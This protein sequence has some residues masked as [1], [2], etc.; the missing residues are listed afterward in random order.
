MPIT[1]QQVLIRNI[2]IRRLPSYY[3]KASSHWLIQLTPSPPCWGTPP[4]PAV[5]PEGNGLAAPAARG[6]HHAVEGHGY[7]AGVEVGCTGG[8]HPA[9]LPSLLYLI[10]HQA[11]EV[12]L[13]ISKPLHPRDVSPTFG[14]PQLL[15]LAGQRLAVYVVLGC[16][17]EDEAEHCD[18]G[19]HIP[20]LWRDKE[21]F[22]GLFTL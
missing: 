22:L 14:Q 9:E 5:I 2:L 11:V 7:T 12:L 16:T 6:T 18:R 21:L 13:L 19:L 1:E 4:P 17:G 8:T 15:Q 10:L 20:R 3:C